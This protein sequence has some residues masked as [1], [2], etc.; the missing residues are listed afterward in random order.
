[1][2]ISHHFLLPPVPE[3][4][5]HEARITALICSVRQSASY[6]F[7]RQSAGNRFKMLTKASSGLNNGPVP[8]APSG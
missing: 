3:S 5:W 1:M 8:F 6:F 2:K 7:T 4:G